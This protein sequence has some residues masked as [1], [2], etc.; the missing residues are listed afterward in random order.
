MVRTAIST[1]PK[2]QRGAAERLLS[3][4]LHGSAHLWH[5][6]PGI[7]VRGAW[8][9]A[10]RRIPA[11][12]RRVA[13]GL[14]VPAAVQLYQQLLEIYQ[15]NPD[16]MVRFASYALLE[17]D[18]RDLKVATCALMLTQPRAGQPIRDERGRI[19][20]HDDDDRAIGEA[21]LL[22]YKRGETKMMNPKAVLRVAQLLEVPQIAA[23]NRRAGFADPAGTKAPLG[24]WKS[25]ARKW[26]RRREENLPLLQGLV[27]AGFKETIKKIARKAGYKPVSQIFF[28]LL[29]WPQKQ[30]MS[31]HRSVGLGDLKLVKKERFDGFSEAEIC[32]WIK[33]ERLGFKDAVGRL[34][35][36]VGLTP[37]IMVAL[38]PTLSDRDLRILTPTLESLGLL[39]VPQI[40]AR[41]KAAIER[42]S[43]QR[44]LNI[45]KNV[46]SESVKE[47][48][49]TASD[50]AIQKAVTRATEDMDLHV[51]FLIDKSG[52]MEMAIEQSKE[53][54]SR[55]L[56]GFAPEKVHIATFD[57]VG[58]IM[59]P[60]APSRR[61]V[62]HML[63]RVRAGGLTNHGAAIRAFSRAGVQIPK[64]AELLLIV[65]GD[66]AGEKGARFADTI[67]QSGYAV[68]AI[69]MIVCIADGW[70]R[71]NSVR[72]CAAALQVPFTELSIDA[73]DDPYHVP[74]AL[75][76]MLEG[77]V[78][79]APDRR[80]PPRQT[81]SKK[82]GMVDRVMQT[83]VIGRDVQV[84]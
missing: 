35:A 43:D 21:M 72:G 67:A 36:D 37:A 33:A 73:F 11:R 5:N 3:L 62:T 13:P 56:A 41:W 31:G 48:L 64:G 47:A 79:N 66:E 49:E 63:S 4:V 39:Q 58:T 74:R 45:M 84:Y 1:L 16:L 81:A 22:W 71:G 75:A 34:P 82:R 12:A 28:E 9:P 20:F 76:A 46:Q 69:G 29:N 40:V 24:R 38:L 15:L 23:L 77:P 8:A 26:L 42:S 68:S 2:E 52:S 53:A 65:C 7:E 80:A 44:A 27:R 59:K 6:R 17:T 55:I 18:W 50:R 30:C 57:N 51:M 70:P 78:P 32:E 10:P 25:A 61:A 60:K 14:F 19:E 54:L 83:P